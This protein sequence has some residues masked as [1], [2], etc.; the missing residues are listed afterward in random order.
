MKYY[1]SLILCLL[2]SLYACRTRTVQ[3]KSS[4]FNTSM[5]IQTKRYPITLFEGN[6]IDNY[7][8]IIPFAVV[9]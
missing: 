2:L 5:K 4:I 1:T 9:E 8:K 3:V 7:S 6:I